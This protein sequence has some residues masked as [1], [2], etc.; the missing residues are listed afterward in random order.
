ML[1]G[2]ASLSHVPIPRWFFLI[3]PTW[4]FSPLHINYL[5]ASFDGLNFSQTFLSKSSIA[6][7]DSMG[8]LMPYLVVLIMLFLT[9]HS[10][11]FLQLFTR[12]SLNGVSVLAS[13][14]EFLANLRLATTSS[15]LLQQFED[16]TL[17]NCTVTDGILYK[18]DLLGFLALTSSY[19]F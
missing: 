19:W 1:Q 2:L 15:G 10:N 14:D 18:D 11:N 4:N 13:S 3:M 8:K 7:V 6:L 5:V 16:G 17:Q 9:L 12:I